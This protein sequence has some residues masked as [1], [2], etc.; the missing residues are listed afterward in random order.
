M[1][2]LIAIRNFFQQLYMQSLSTGRVFSAWKVARL[3]AVFK[4]DD[5]TVREN[6]R[7][8]SILSVP[9]K[10]LESCVADTLVKHTFIDNQL[11]TERQ[12]A[13]RKGHSTELLLTDG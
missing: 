3:N 5:E 9:S 11:V 8:L 1:K 7:P 6:Y 4:K 12:W 13:Y 2:C 10:I